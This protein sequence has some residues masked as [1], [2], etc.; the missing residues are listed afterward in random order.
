MSYIGHYV[1]QFVAEG[2]PAPATARYEHTGGCGNTV[3]VNKGEKM[4]PCGL[5][6]CPNK[7]A[8]WRLIAEPS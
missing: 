6:N 1:G 3:I 7:K 2:A 5:A 4:P 8:S